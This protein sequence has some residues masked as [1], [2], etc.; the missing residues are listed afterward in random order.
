[1]T[2][3]HTERE[4]TCGSGVCSC[5][6]Y[7]ATRN[8]YFTGKYMTAHDFRSE[9][10]Y[11]LSRHRLHNRSLHGWGIVCGLDVVEHP[12]EACRNQ[13]VVVKA[14]IALDCCGREVVLE[15]DTA[16][17][18]AGRAMPRDDADRLESPVLLGISYKEDL[19]EPVPVLYHEGECDPTR[20]EANRVRESVQLHV[21]QHIPDGCWAQPGGGSGGCKCNEPE[22]D[23]CHCLE[24]DCV[25]GGM[26]PLALL[27]FAEKPDSPIEIDTRGRTKINIAG[28]Y[29]TYVTWTNFKHGAEVTLAELRDEMQ[30]RIEIRF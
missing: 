15:K 10:D 19:I 7:V 4:C 17:E 5:G 30:G 12:N 1:V 24:V 9:Q 11:F 20:R 14:G 13:W 21:L 29:L 22:H 3:G 28:E 26:V 25:C 8:R 16:F 6:S 23:D 18:L 2:R 27:S